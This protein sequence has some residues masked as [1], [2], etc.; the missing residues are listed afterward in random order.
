MYEIAPAFLGEVGRAAQ[1]VASPTGNLDQF[2]AQGPQLLV[3]GAGDGLR[4]DADHAEAECLCASR[5]SQGR[6]SH[7]GHDQLARVPFATQLVEQMRRAANLETT[8]RGKELA[9]RVNVMTRKEVA[10]ADQR[11]RHNGKHDSWSSMGAFTALSGCER[12]ATT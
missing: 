3:L 10:Q 12:S 4:H 7:R 8:G 6:V 2:D 1:Q 11:R 5:R 9:L